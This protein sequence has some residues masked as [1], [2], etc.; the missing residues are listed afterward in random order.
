MFV[1]RSSLAVRG[2]R[3]AV[4]AVLCVCSP[5][6]MGASTAAPEGVVTCATPDVWTGAAR[7][8][9]VMPIE[10]DAIRVVHRSDTVWR[11][12]G[13][14]GVD[15]AGAAGG[16]AYSMTIRS[17]YRGEGLWGLRGRNR[18]AVQRRGPLWNVDASTYAV[19]Q[20][21]M[22][23]IL[24]RS[25]ASGAKRDA[26]GVYFRARPE[27][28]ERILERAREIIAE[29]MSGRPSAGRPTPSGT[30]SASFD[31][32]MLRMQGRW[33]NDPIQ[34]VEAL[35]MGTSLYMFGTSF[36]VHVPAELVDGMW[37]QID[38]EGERVLLVGAS[39]RP[40]MNAQSAQAVRYCGGSALMSR[41]PTPTV[42]GRDAGG[43]A[44][45][46]EGQI[47]RP[48]MGDVVMVVQAPP[49][50]RGIEIALM[51]VVRR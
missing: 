27:N 3:T 9:E 35:P 16:A 41:F 49:F 19:G 25:G 26:R 50:G 36:V 1:A 45:D 31:V 32:A 24:I 2:R 28:R 46:A 14:V 29:R 17:S 44:I 40:V 30:A 12:G 7:L 37:D 38:M 34:F 39:S 18:A 47:L 11:T 4:A 51:R 6:L 23:E 10:G 15:E 22:V 13:T 42:V 48:R 33:S 21:E 5:L 20:P 43:L 8:S